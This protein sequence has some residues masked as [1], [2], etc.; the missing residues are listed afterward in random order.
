MGKHFV[1]K[2]E[3]QRGMTPQDVCREAVMWSLLDQLFWREGVA[4]AACE[5]PR[6]SSQYLVMNDDL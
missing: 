3:K 1:P 4:G 5:M 2:L 6:L